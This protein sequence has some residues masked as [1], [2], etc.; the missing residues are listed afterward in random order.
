MIFSVLVFKS[1]LLLYLV[2]INVVYNGLLV[3]YS[4]L[5]ESINQFKPVCYKKTSEWNFYSK[6]ILLKYFLKNRKH[7]IYLWS[8]HFQETVL[9][10]TWF[11]ISRFCGELMVF[12]F[13]DPHFLYSLID[14]IYSILL[15]TKH[16]VPHV[17][18]DWL[19]NIDS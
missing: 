14:D 15:F 1:V 13:R 2:I 12:H 9:C 5:Y 6:W 8:N 16:K 10:R 11:I 7:L 3:F 4:D 18:F 17:Q 19:K